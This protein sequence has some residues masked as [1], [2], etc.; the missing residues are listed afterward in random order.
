MPV[1]GH[2][3]VLVLA[4]MEALRRARSRQGRVRESAFSLL[5]GDGLLTHA[6]EGALEPSGEEARGLDT[7]RPESDRP[8]S[9]GPELGRPGSRGPEA[10]LLRL[11]SEAAAP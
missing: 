7:D 4:A 9:D 5:T 6:C 1:Q 10:V 3:Q 8:E 11:I 2:V